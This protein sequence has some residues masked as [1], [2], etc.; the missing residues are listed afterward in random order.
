MGKAN[1]LVFE[2]ASFTDAVFKFKTGAAY[3]HAVAK[4]TRAAAKAMGAEWSIYDKDDTPKNGPKKWELDYELRN[5]TAVFQV[6]G[7]G[8]MPPQFH[9]ELNVPLLDRVSIVKI[10]GKKKAKA[11]YLAARFRMLIDGRESEILEFRRQVRS[12]EGTLTLS[13]REDQQPA[14]AN[15]LEKADGTPKKNSELFAVPP[16]DLPPGHDPKVEEVTFVSGPVEIRPGIA[17]TPVEA[18]STPVE[19]PAQPP[20]EDTGAT[21]VVFDEELK[22]PEWYARLRIVQIDAGYLASYWIRFGTEKRPLFKHVDEMLLGSPKHAL[23]DGA[24]Q[25]II[26]C[27][28]ALQAASF[29]P[30]MK[31]AAAHIIEWAGTLK[32]ASVG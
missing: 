10:G 24:A 25:I 21:R 2:K 15:L 9:L 13:P 19:T 30:K 22:K 28:Q 20:A 5:A 31:P 3:L 17:P 27:N 32:K 11:T 1:N 23:D 4:L 14:L 26:T 18:E 6:A 16:A 8:K 29:E 7:V 12:G